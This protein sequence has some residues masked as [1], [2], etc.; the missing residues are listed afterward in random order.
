MKAATLLNRLPRPADARE[1]ADT[2]QTRRRRRRGRRTRSNTAGKLHLASHVADQADH[3]ADQAS[4]VTDP[5]AASTAGAAQQADVARVRRAGGPIDNA[6]YTC[7]C[8]YVF[9]ASVSTTVACPHCGADQ[10]W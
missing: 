10:A 6:S 1:S 4:P 7:A 9:A 8:G 5:A 3:V 2:E